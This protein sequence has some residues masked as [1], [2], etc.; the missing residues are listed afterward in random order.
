MEETISI[1]LRDPEHER[2][3]GVVFNITPAQASVLSALSR[4]TIVSSDDLIEFIGPK[5]NVRVVVSRT[6]AAMKDLGMDIKSKWKVGY[7][8]EASDRD[9]VASIVNEF[10]KS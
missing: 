6:R 5:A 8:M 4:G 3:L 10:L 2:V 9:R 7:Y 1:P